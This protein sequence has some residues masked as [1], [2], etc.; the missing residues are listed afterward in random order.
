MTSDISRSHV[1]INGQTFAKDADTD[2]PAVYAAFKKALPAE[3][4]QKAVSSLMHQG[5]LGD[6][7]LTL[8][9]HP[10]LPDDGGDPRGLFNLPGADLLF[11]RDMTAE[12][13]IFE[14]PQ[15]DGNQALDYDLEVTPDGNTAVL[16]M[17]MQSPIMMGNAENV[18]EGFGQIRI[19]QKL[20][21]DLTPDV[22]VVT[23]VN[24]SQIINS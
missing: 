14:K 17:R 12:N 7:T 18:D 6:L 22:P 5:G 19:A 23:D 2:F 4:A 1:V 10:I 21:I 11:Q 20:T 3:K 24:I 13:A 15:F 9:K 8:M 16:T